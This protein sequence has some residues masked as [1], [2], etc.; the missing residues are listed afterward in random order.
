MAKMSLQ[1]H[2][3]TNV[4]ILTTIGLAVAVALLAHGVSE[5][6]HGGKRRGVG[7]I[8]LG[9][10]SAVVII[11]MAVFIPLDKPRQQI[12]WFVIIGLVIA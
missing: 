3:T 11:L 9:S 7:E 6:L 2:G 8:L 10:L 12:L 5:L 4:A 1:F